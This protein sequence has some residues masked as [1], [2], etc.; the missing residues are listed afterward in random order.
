MKNQDL[1][2]RRKAEL[3]KLSGD[4]E[5][6]G[7][8]VE[9]H[10]M[11]TKAV[12][13]MPQMFYVVKDDKLVFCNRQLAAF[14]DLPAGVTA[15]RTPWSVMMQEMIAA[16]ISDKV[17]R[18]EDMKTETLRQ[19]RNNGIFRKSW[20]LQDGRCL[21]IEAMEG[22]DGEVIVTYSDVTE[23]KNAR[24]KAEAAERAKAAFLA[25]M[26]HEI[27]TPM[28]GV[29]G[30]AELL[31][32][33]ALSDT[34][35]TY[36]STI[37]K[38]GEALLNI[39]NDILDFSKID[40][41]EMKLHAAP[42]SLAET[43]NDVAVLISSRLSARS[44]ELAVRIQPD[45]PDI[46]V[47]D[48]GRFRQVIVNLMGNAA[49][50]TQQ[51]HILVHV[52]GEPDAGEAGRM[53]LM[54]RVEDTGPGIPEDKRAS[55][56]DKFSQV[57]DTATRKFE[58]TGLG[59][60]IASS[61]VSL[62]RGRIGVESEIGKGSAFW[63]EVSLPVH[64]AQE[65]RPAVPVDL[66]GVRIAAIDDNQV[67]RS[68]LEEQLKGW[69]FDCAL[70]ASG[71]EGLQGLRERAEAGKGADL[72]ILDHHMPGMTGADV[73]M[74]IRMDERLKHMPIVMLTSVDEAHD[75]AAFTSLGADAHLIKPARASA[76]FDAIVRV[77]QAR[78]ADSGRADAPPPAAAHETP[79]PPQTA[80]PDHSHEILIAED[81]E[82][83]RLVISHI[84]QNAGYRFKMAHDGEEAVRM[85]AELSPSLILMDV[86][87]PVVTGYDAAR[88]I[89]AAEAGTGKRTPIIAVT[90]HAI[91]DDRDKCLE[92]GMDDYV[93]KP[94]SPTR[95]L[96][97]LAHW[98]RESAESAA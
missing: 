69:G 85:H 66:T 5:A 82:V 73:A 23:L 74:L 52:S 4:R 76:L 32:G 18:V 10:E 37:L 9:Q 67:N 22:E 63:F 25:N 60:A 36:A 6:L 95:L 21:L 13:A 54:V 41:G 49:K 39:I 80:A 14:Y 71:H 48:A 42:F 64:D 90:A 17:N 86:S 3:D 2:N 20:T 57:D 19:I 31:C 72:V 43:I 11:L 75:G 94:I 12:H 44:V 92:A 89:R 27:R 78:T 81:N 96:D 34:Q 16:H 65:K 79:A 35:R 59:L 55:I 77:L 15:A 70:Y 68:I 46:F 29:M 1:H 47:G 87:M 53:R 84:L 24:R 28:N 40:A 98:L 91:K 38:S 83:N 58:G 62:M 93:S 56:F 45:L 7:A 88:A 97:R 33:T 61:L 8:L 51:G 26:S 30:M 50:F